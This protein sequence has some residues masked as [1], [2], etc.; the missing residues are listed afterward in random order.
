MVS[1]ESGLSLF[2]SMTGMV[3]ISS[4]IYDLVD[5]YSPILVVLGMMTF[6]WFSEQSIQIG[7]SKYIGGG[8]TKDCKTYFFGIFASRKSPFQIFNLG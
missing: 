3:K 1:V 8:S 5:I 6:L 2:A 7:K 4:R